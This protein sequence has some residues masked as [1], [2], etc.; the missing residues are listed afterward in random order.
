MITTIHGLMDETTLEKR[1]G[2]I[3][4]EVEETNWVEYWLGTELVHRSVHV[5]LK[6]MPTLFGE[7]GSI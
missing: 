6:R 7:T 4:D 5:R 1:E 3:D 2:S